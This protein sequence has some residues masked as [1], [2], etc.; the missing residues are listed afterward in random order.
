[1]SKKRKLDMDNNIDTKRIK[2]IINNTTSRKRKMDHQFTTNPKRSKYCNSSKN[3]KRGRK[4]KYTE[5]L[6][7][8]NIKCPQ[9]TCFMPYIK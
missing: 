8:K 1:M 6:Y 4:R 7:L 3:I 2:I 9:P 5:I